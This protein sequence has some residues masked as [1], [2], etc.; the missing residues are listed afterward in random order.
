MLARQQRFGPR[1]RNDRDGD[2]GIAL[3]IDAQRR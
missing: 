3:R 2:T 1:A